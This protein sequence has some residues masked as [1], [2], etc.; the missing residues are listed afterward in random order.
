[1]PFPVVVLGAN[2]WGTTK[3]VGAGSVFP[4][5]L[6]HRVAN[7]TARPTTVERADDYTVL[8]VLLVASP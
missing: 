7:G 6:H 2:A 3:I 5:C 8:S 1:M 4:H